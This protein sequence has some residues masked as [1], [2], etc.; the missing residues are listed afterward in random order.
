M[1]ASTPAFMLVPMIFFV[2]ACPSDAPRPD[3]ADTAP[4]TSDVAPGDAP[5]GTSDDT[6]DTVGDVTP[7]VA[8]T[9]NDTGV[10][11]DACSPFVPGGVTLTGEGRFR[12]VVGLPAGAGLL[13]RGVT[14]YLPDGFDPSG[15]TR[16]PVLYMHDG[17]NLFEPGATAFGEWGV[18]E[19]IDDLARRGVVPP[20]LVVAIDNTDERIADYTP[21]ADPGYGGGNAEAYGTWL[22]STLKPA[23]D[24]LLPTRCEREHTAVAGSSLGGLVSTFLALR[25]PT[26]FGRV[27]AVSPSY[28][29]DGQRLLRD[30]EAADAPMP[31]RVWID[32]GTL[33][34]DTSPHDLDPGVAHA[35]RA[36]Q[37]AIA[38]G[39]VVGRDVAYYEAVGYQHNETAWRQRLPSILG[40]LL[41]DDGF[42]SLPGDERLALLPSGQGLYLGGRPHLQFVAELQ[43]SPG[44]RPFRMTLPRAALSATGPVTFDADQTVTATAI[45]EAILGAT[46]GDHTASLTLP[47][48]PVGLAP[49]VFEVQTPATT[50]EGATVYLSGDLPALGDGDP[51]GVAL[52]VPQGRR[53]KGPELALPIDT[54]FHYRYTLGTDASGESDANG[55]PIAPRTG[56]PI[57]TEGAHIVDLV[58]GWET[59]AA[60]PRVRV[61]LFTHIE[62]QSPAGTLGSPQSRQSYLELRARLIEVAERARDEG[63]PWVFQP[64]WKI[65]EAALLY[66]DAALTAS[67]G[68]HNFLVHLRDTLGV[69]IDPHSHENGGYNYTDVAYLLDRFGVGGSTVIGGHIWDPALSQFQQW[70]RFRVPVPGEKYPEFTWRGDI[71]TGSGTPN[72]VNDPLLSGLWRPKDR[73]HYFVDDPGGN[74]VCVGAW[75]DGVPGVVELVGLYAD[76]TVPATTLLTASWNIRPADITAPDGPATIAETVFRPL[77][78][79]QDRGEIELT[80]FTSLVADWRAAGGV[81]SIYQP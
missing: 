62:D 10:G 20:T 66:E 76:G 46:W 75:H 61:V 5:D 28:W 71:L 19:T 26:I 23:I 27:G 72:H 67:T 38:R 22:A 79:M 30:L 35:R 16:Y 52:G 77:K 50:S 21:S 49:V 18:D 69:A 34:G 40:F 59:P 60:R 2:G 17:Q 7:E 1:R 39:L 51:A 25:W 73:D 43:R 81:A 48:H 80:D 70:D 68:G 64:D 14:V 24:G 47:I 56:G 12:E 33:E 36:F 55:N 63:V 31:H 45:G 4:D 58:R 53:V 78:A 15:T 9:S 42:A 29:W 3:A 41:S 6:G 32:M 8:D 57:A 65:L 54:P 44:L 74:I 37:A 11:P 13:P